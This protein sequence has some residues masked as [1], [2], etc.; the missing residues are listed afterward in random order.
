MPSEFVSLGKSAKIGTVQTDTVGSK[1]KNG[2]G[3]SY[4]VAF[5]RV[6]QVLQEIELEYIQEGKFLS[7]YLNCCLQNFSTCG[8]SFIPYT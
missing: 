4:F 2:R 3:F 7:S 5:H 8:N 1:E 6:V